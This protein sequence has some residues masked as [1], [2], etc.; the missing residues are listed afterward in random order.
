MKEILDAYA[1]LKAKSDLQGKDLTE[2]AQDFRNLHAALQ[3]KVEMVGGSRIVDLAIAYI[4]K[5]E[6]GRKKEEDVKENAALER[7]SA[8]GPP[9]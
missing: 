5:L 4:R 2:I 6:E 3:G 9:R 7:V 1:D 8:N